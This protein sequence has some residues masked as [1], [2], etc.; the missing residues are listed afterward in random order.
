MYNFDAMS[1]GV[2]LLFD[3]FIGQNIYT[4]KSYNFSLLVTLLFASSSS[5]SISSTS[6]QSE[7]SSSDTIGELQVILS[8]YFHLC[9]QELL[10][11]ARIVFIYSDW[12]PESRLRLVRVWWLVVV[13]PDSF[14][15]LGE[16]RNSAETA[17]FRSIRP[18]QALLEPWR[19]SISTISNPT[20]ELCL[21]DVASTTL[22]LEH[23]VRTRGKVF[24]SILLAAAW[25]SW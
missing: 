18:H 11:R 22:L 2:V 21:Y 13:L 25:L 1:S 14:R 12:I 17:L 23:N 6:S 10:Y 24:A 8:L 3:A 9:S 16:R 4:F 7:T 20:K 15:G 19:R 5:V